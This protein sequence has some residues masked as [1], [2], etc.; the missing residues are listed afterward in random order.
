[1]SVKNSKNKNT[2]TFGKLIRAVWATVVH[3]HNL[4]SVGNKFSLQIWLTPIITL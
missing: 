2:A 1:M 4:Y 3:V